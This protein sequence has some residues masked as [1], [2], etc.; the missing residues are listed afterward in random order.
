M[1]TFLVACYLVC[2][3]F[4]VFGLWNVRADVPLNAE[5]DPFQVNS[6]WKG[7]ITQ[8]GTHPDWGFIPAELSSAFVITR[9][10]GND[11]EAELHENTDSLDIT[12]VCKGK[13]QTLSD[14]AFML[15][16][17][18]VEIKAAQ[19][20]TVGLTGVQY[21]AKVSGKSLKG[22]WK[23]PQNNRGI[24]LEGDFEWTQE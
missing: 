11:F 19:V 10:D 16:F 24:T 2:L 9:R 3:G 22:D 6:H 12:F 13:V 14:C 18:S 4:L 7:T 1:K 21:T 5:E 17:D 23:Y 8:R 20:G 15:T